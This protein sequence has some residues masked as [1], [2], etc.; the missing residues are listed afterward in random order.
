MKIVDVKVK[1]EMD[2]LRIPGVVGVLARDKIIVMVE[3]RSGCAKVPK[4][5]D[6]VRVECKVV[7]KIGFR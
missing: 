5:L 7:G 6:G 2:L 3:D 4:E 1:Y